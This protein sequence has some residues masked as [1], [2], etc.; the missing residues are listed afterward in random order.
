ML[1][2]T[3]EMIVLIDINYLDNFYYLIA[4]C[5]KQQSL[6]EWH[7]DS[8]TALGCWCSAKELTGAVTQ[9]VFLETE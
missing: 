5:Q 3:V 4:S 1:R 6:K 9:C 2:T 7:G 8:E